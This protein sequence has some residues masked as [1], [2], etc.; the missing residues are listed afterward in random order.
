MDFTFLNK[1]HVSIVT[2]KNQ[3]DFMDIQRKFWRGSLVDFGIDLKNVFRKGGEFT[4]NSGNQMRK[5]VALPAGREL[6]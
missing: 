1:L 4:S 3:F 2:G 6:V 5:V